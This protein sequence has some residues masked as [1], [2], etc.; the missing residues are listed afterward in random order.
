MM[1]LNLTLFNGVGWGNGPGRMDS[2][3]SPPPLEARVVAMN[4][5]ANKRVCPAASQRRA[6]ILTVLVLFSGVSR[7]VAWIDFGL[8]LD[9]LKW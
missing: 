6:D 4:G 9:W 8:P 2:S 5:N 7:W 1:A 3:S